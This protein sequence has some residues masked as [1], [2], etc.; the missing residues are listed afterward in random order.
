M[1]LVHLNRFQPERTHILF[2][3]LVLR[4]GGYR[5]LKSRFNIENIHSDKTAALHFSLIVLSHSGRLTSIQCIECFCHSH[6]SA[7]VV[8][9]V[10]VVVQSPFSIYWTMQ[11]SQVCVAQVCAKRIGNHKKDC[12]TRIQS[13]YWE[14][15]SS[16]GKKCHKGIYL[17]PIAGE[18]GRDEPT[19]I[20]SIE[21]QR[22]LAVLINWSNN[23]IWLKYSSG[24]DVIPVVRTF[25]PTKLNENIVDKTEG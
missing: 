14:I 23:I 1:H 10:V 21:Y 6:K 4:F 22:M 8:V 5:L 18:W 17:S 2:I 12:I 20:R 25:S 19:T 15:A 16:I 7:F 13:E 9:F 3:R 24:N 11:T